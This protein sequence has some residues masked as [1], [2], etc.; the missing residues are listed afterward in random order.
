[1]HK[2][3]FTTFL[4]SE[5]RYS[6]NTVISYN[7]DLTQ[8]EN[9]VFDIFGCNEIE[10]ATFDMIRSWIA[11]LIDSEISATTV[12]RKICTLRSFFKFLVSNGVIQSNPTKKI[13]VPKKKVRVTNYI[14]KQIMNKIL[15]DDNFSN[16][17]IGRRNFLIIEFFYYTG[18]RVSELINIK[19]K[20]FDFNKNKVKIFG[21]SKKERNVP[22]TAKFSKKIKNFISDFQITEYLFTNHNNKKLYNKKI[23]RLVKKHLSLYSSKTNNSPHILRHS[24][25]THMLDNGADINAVKELLGHSSLTATQIYTHNSI[26]KIK[27]IYKNTHPRA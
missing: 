25:A 26:A 3:S 17:F 23:Y 20:D 19:I 7:N 15:S 6:L 2:K 21:K 11:M 22:M 27:N 16:D 13:I 14:S 8:F 5:K 4:K 12:N 10:K 24:F 9:F 1:M 18:V